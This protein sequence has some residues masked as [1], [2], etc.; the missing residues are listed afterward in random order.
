MKKGN[1]NHNNVKSL[2]TAKFILAIQI[3]IIG[4]Y[5]NTSYNE[6]YT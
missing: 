3:F 5:I 4:L 6:Y 2:S 1:L